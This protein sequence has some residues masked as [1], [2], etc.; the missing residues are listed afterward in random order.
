MAIRGGDMMNKRQRKKQFKKRYGASPEQFLRQLNEAFKKLPD[1]LSGLNRVIKNMVD[2]TVKFIG[3]F[4][5]RIRDMTE[6]EYQSV[7][8]N[9]KL[10]EKD[11]LLLKKYRDEGGDAIDRERIKPTTLHN[12]G[13]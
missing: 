1:I 7:L 11:K 5:Q 10:S 2:F 9:P 13:D 12:Q 6:E 3:E 8:N 4:P